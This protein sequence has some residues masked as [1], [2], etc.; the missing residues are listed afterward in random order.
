MVQGTPDTDPV[1][2]TLPDADCPPGLSDGTGH[3]LLIN[4]NLIQGNSADSGSGGGIRLQQV[5]GTEVSTFPGINAITAASEGRTVTIRTRGTLPA[6]G[7]SVTIAGVS[8]AGYNGTFTVTGVRPGQF[9]Y[10]GAVGGLGTGTGG[11]FTDTTTA[12]TAQPIISASETGP[13]V[14]TITS[15]LSPT[16]GDRVTVS[17]VTPAGYNGTFTVTGVPAV[18]MFT[19]TDT[20]NLAAATAFGT[21]TDLSQSST[22]LWNSVNITNN[23]IVNNMAGWDGAGISLQDALNVNIVS[24]TIAHND[25]L[26]SSG[27]LTFSIGTPLSSAPAGE[28]H[29]TAGTASC[30]QSAGVTSTPNS[31]ILT[32]TFAG[33]PG[34]AAG[35]HCPAGH[36]GCAGFSNPILYN[37]IVWQNRSFYVGIAGAGTGIQN[38]QNQIALFT[39]SGAAAPVQTATGQCGAASYW[40]LGVRGDRSATTHESGF[41]LAPIWSVIAGYGGQ[42]NRSINPGV[43]SQYCNGSRVP[44][45]C[46]V[47]S[48]CA[49]PHGFGVPPGIPDSLAGAPVFA[50][51]PSATVDE[52]NNWINVSWGPLA[53]SN[54][55]FTGGL[56]GNY[57]GGPALGNYQLA[58]GSPAIDQIP[59]PGNAPPCVPPGFAAGV[60]T[61]LTDFYGNP[62][63]DSNGAFDIG[64]VESKATGVP[65]PAAVAEVT[66]GPLN[67]GT[68]LAGTNSPAQTLTLINTGSVSLTGISEQIPGG[69]PFS[70]PGGAA[71]GTCAGTLAAGASCTIN[72]VFHPTSGTVAVPVTV[73]STLSFTASVPVAGSPVTLTG[74]GN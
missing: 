16:V 56:Y 35:I 40:D 46:P 54:D 11:T 51:V 73:S 3:N 37:D 62:R 57:G 53:L 59:C 21:V 17:G 22:T 38:Q 68:V 74:T 52:G 15:G 48:G 39:A 20:A 31:S 43:V 19:Y 7:N 47:A 23:I 44:P 28:C 66:G 70:R 5:N 10:F 49:G 9:T 2:G 14:V 24:N 13:G 29:N 36:P 64:A 26:A 72:V 6:V 41:T 67:F 61:P 65:A 55:S 12:G 42:G 1:C 33:V 32:T 30:P 18:G 8:V 71:G 4:A 25:T 63:P 60:T 58:A 69:S 27:V 34:G 50:F 45:E